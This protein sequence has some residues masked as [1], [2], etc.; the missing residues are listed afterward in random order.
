MTAASAKRRW[1]FV[2]VTLSVVVALV[3]AIRL[4]PPAAEPAPEV[5]F[6]TEDGAAA[7]LPGS[8]LAT[9][10]G[11]GALRLDTTSYAPRTIAWEWT[12]TGAWFTVRF[13]DGNIIHYS[14]PGTVQ[15]STTN[16]TFLGPTGLPRVRVPRVVV[17]DEGPATV[18]LRRDYRRF[19]GAGSAEARDVFLVYDTGSPLR[20]AA[21]EVT[22]HVAADPDAEA[23]GTYV[24]GEQVSLTWQLPQGNRAQPYLPAGTPIVAELRLRM[25]SARTGHGEVSV[26]FPEGLEV[27]RLDT[28]AAPTTDGVVLDFSLAAGYQE[29]TW[30]FT[31]RAAAAGAI[32]ARLSGASPE[33]LEVVTRYAVLE[34]A[35]LGTALKVTSHGAYPLGSG[36]DAGTLRTQLRNDLRLREGLNS[37]LQRLFGGR[38]SADAPAGVVRAVL[39]NSSSQDLV[40]HVRYQVLDARGEEIEA[41]RGEHLQQASDGESALPEA[42]LL[43][44]AGRSVDWRAPLYADVY[45]IAPGTYTGRFEARLFGSRLPLWSS[46]DEL[47]VHKD[48]QLQLLVTLVGLVLAA[49]S[50]ALFALK[51]RSWLA[52]MRTSQLILLAL[53]TA[54][55][56]AVIDVPWTVL[57]DAIRA[58]LGPLGPFVQLGTGIFS[59]ILQALFLTALIVLVP[60]PGVAVISGLVRVI[61][62]AV[63]F[64]SFNPVSISLTL[65]YALLADLLLYVFGF[66]RGRLPLGSRRAALALIVIFA[67]QHVYSTYTFYYTW[68]YMYRLFYPDWYIGLNALISVVYSA[69]GA[70]LGLLL[71]A[72]LKKVID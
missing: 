16:V 35:G 23:G 3:V 58:F 2:V 44:P 65:S 19:F 69:V 47:R 14:L 9:E 15:P 25:F 5:V 11:S 50:V 21:L 39:Y 49:G 46:E 60:K 33:P 61:L 28:R 31:V 20:V 72:R 12:G 13:S 67:V 7:W 6:T 48:D 42:V 34:P 4:R 41:F 27:T 38:E 68:M 53:I 55:K 30:Y 52:G 1:P 29:Q 37:S 10:A 45:N 40:L 24:Q 18:D 64:G 57:G 63:A 54:V 66:T 22:T 8:G 62:G 43:L 17:L 71:G 32:V 26:T 51:Q 70:V 36:S 59:D 56:F